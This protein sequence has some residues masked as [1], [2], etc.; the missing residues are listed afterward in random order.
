MAEAEWDIIECGYNAADETINFG[1]RQLGDAENLYESSTL[2]TVRSS[3]D[4][5]SKRFKTTITLF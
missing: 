1:T 5:V 4:N 2:A 3:T